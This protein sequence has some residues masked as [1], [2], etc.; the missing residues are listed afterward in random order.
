MYRLHIIKR[1]LLFLAPPDG[2]GIGHNNFSD[3]DD[4]MKTR[5]LRWMVIGF[6]LASSTGC[7]SGSCG[8]R[9]TFREWFQN[10]P[11]PLRDL[12]TRG[13]ECSEC[14]APAGEM[15]L[16]QF[17]PDGN[18]LSAAPNPGYYPSDMMPVSGD[19]GPAP[20]TSAGYPPANG[21]GSG[22][23]SLNS[24]AEL[25]LPPMYGRSN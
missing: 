17:C 23:K 12:F 14:S 3:W 16:G 5:T 24:N 20:R 21:I 4:H 9:M 13:E 18:C 19:P 15:E 25:E 1:G 22:V 2:L 6:L 7:S 8:P 10:R 11:R